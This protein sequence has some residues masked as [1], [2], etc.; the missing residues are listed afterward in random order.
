MT[1]PPPKAAAHGDEAPGGQTSFRSQ[2][3]TVDFRFLPSGRSGGPQGLTLDDSKGVVQTGP[4]PALVILP[5]R[6]DAC[7]VLGPLPLLSLVFPSG[8]FGF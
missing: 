3:Q 8:I 5:F 4:A 6:P 2:Q 1:Q 7:C